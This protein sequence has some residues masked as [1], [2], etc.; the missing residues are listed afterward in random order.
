MNSVIA[1]AAKQSSAERLLFQFIMQK[2][3][4]AFGLA[5]TDSGNSY[6]TLT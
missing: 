2:I 5:M 1:S 6:K 3:A 4:T